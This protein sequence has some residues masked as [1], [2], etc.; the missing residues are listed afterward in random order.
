MATA[1]AAFK[2]Q[3]TALVP[4]VLEP[5]PVIDNEQVHVLHVEPNSIA[6]DIV[7]AISDSVS[8]VIQ[9]LQVAAV[10]STIVP[11]AQR[12]RQHLPFIEPYKVRV[13][14]VD[15]H[16]A[17]RGDAV[18]A[19]EPVNAVSRWLEYSPDT[20]RLLLLYRHRPAQ[21][22][23]ASWIGA[24]AGENRLRS[25]SEYLS[26]AQFTFS[27]DGVASRALSAAAESPAPDPDTIVQTSAAFLADPLDTI[28]RRASSF[29]S[30]RISTALFDHA[31]AAGAPQA[32]LD[33]IATTVGPTQPITPVS[34]YNAD[35]SKATVRS[36]MVELAPALLA[37]VN[38]GYTK[39][40][41][42]LITRTAFLAAV[43][44]WS[45]AANCHEIHHALKPDDWLGRLIYDYT[46]LLRG[47]P[48]NGT[49]EEEE[50]LK[51]QIIARYGAMDLPTFTEFVEFYWRAQQVFPGQSIFVAKTDVRRAYHL[52]RW[53]PTGSLQLAL[54]ITDDVIMVPITWGFGSREAPYAFSPVSSYVDWAHL[55]RMLAQGIPAPLSGTFIDD[56][57]TFGPR[58]F[59]DDEVAA[60]EALLQAAL[61]P[62]AVNTAKRSVTTCDDVLGIRFDTVSARAGLSHKAF[63]KLLYVFFVCL[64]EQMTPATKVNLHTVQVIA[65]LAHCYGKLFPLL[66]HTA[67]V[68]YK[69][70]AGSQH[71]TSPRYLD[72][73]QLANVEL[74]R[75]FLFVAHSH[76][77]IASTPLIDAYYNDPVIGGNVYMA[78]G[79]E[80]YSDASEE[81]LGGYVPGVGWFEITVEDLLSNASLAPDTKIPI[82][83]LELIAYI[84]VYLFAVAVQPDAN[85][86][87]IHV[88]NQNAQQWA[89]GHISTKSDIANN[90][91]SLNSYLQVF[92]GILQTRSYIRSAENIVADAISRRRFRR[93]TQLQEYRLQPHLW[94]LLCDLLTAPASC[95]WPT[96]ANALTTLGCG[97]SSLFSPL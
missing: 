21:A 63:L 28:D 4:A 51:A 74:W 10:A 97:A 12:P 56:T 70:L 86:V 55:Q 35:P 43:E 93:S 17:R 3:S 22:H 90:C 95:A 25:F 16:D 31:L 94:R 53:T 57:V 29:A 44:T 62:G 76:A 11:A 87:H 33:R 84:V 19:C 89:A 66:R 73:R 96:Q 42:L 1:K 59:L 40:E 68:F 27:K 50:W 6:M 36:A 79:L 88:D 83:Y 39:G 92:L 78:G 34:A 67:S 13:L 71:A 77:S 23:I 24:S 47:T 91:V 37:L 85:H 61:H 49:P 5:E 48:H 45:L 14:G 80:V 38:V 9:P 7:H 69:A 75:N 54:R 26:L 60:H 2:V 30:T 32:L 46:N 58:P 41:N 8:A 18:R 64:P 81:A 65:S 20:Q 52:Q 72:D 15:Y 82:A